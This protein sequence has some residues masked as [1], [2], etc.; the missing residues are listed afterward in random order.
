VAELKVLVVTVVHVPRD[1]RIF[2]RQIS[3]MLEAGV[4]VTYAAPWTGWGQQ[5]PPE[6]RGID[7]PRA[8]GRQRIGALRA[9]RRMLRAEAPSHDLVLLHDPELLLIAGA[10]RKHTPVVWDVHEDAAA[11]LVA[12]PWVPV[13]LRPLVRAL[14]G[15]AERVA[16]R[17]LKLT[18]A[19][20]A[21]QDRFARPHP[22][23][24]NA[25]L[26]VDVTVASGGSRIVYLGRV[27]AARGAHELVEV[28]RRLRDRV[29]LEVIGDAESDVAPVLA[30]A[31]ERGDIVWTG[32]VP[33]REALSRVVGAAAGLSLLHDLPNFQGS[34]PTKVLEYLACGVPVVTTPLPLAVEVVQDADAGHVVPFG[35]VDAVVRAVEALLSDDQ[36]RVAA[37]ERGRSYIAEH[38]A[39]QAHAPAFVQ[40]LRTWAADG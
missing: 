3:A 19:E 2:E 36:A 29:T 27:A 23:V 18:L 32:Y 28:G 17:H 16:E 25:P 6:L 4:D 12:R 9:A 13:V 11:S 39:W 15:A 26:L 30:A 10:A 34:M 22:V 31:A 37:G 5:P 8:A 20:H 24:P 38:H 40:L 21:Y 35:D 1:A 33:N 7:L 14:I